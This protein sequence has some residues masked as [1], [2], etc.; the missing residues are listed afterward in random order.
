MNRLTALLG[1]SFLVVAE[2]GASFAQP[3]QLVLL[4]AWNNLAGPAGTAAVQMILDGNR[5]FVS[6]L[7]E[8]PQQKIVNALVFDSPSDWK[9]TQWQKSVGEQGSSFSSQI[10]AK[11]ISKSYTSILM[12]YTQRDSL[13]DK[14]DVGVEAQ[15]RFQVDIAATCRTKLLSAQATPLNV[16]MVIPIRPMPT[17]KFTEQRCDYVP[18]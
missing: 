17:T 12:D 7:P 8:K 16:H 3:R 9:C 4:F 10:C 13:G 1:A 5:I 6:A 18:R 14:N 15:I 11:L 2:I